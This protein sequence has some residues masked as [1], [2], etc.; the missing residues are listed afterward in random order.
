V[1]VEV[2]VQEQLQTNQALTQ[3]EEVDL[4]VAES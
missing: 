3:L 4:V 2:V 1:V